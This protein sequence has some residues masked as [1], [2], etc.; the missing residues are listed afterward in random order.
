MNFSFVYFLV[1]PLAM[2]QY[3]GK[4]SHKSPPQEQFRRFNIFDKVN[5]LMLQKMSNS[6]ILE[7]F[8]NSIKT[9]EQAKKDREEQEKRNKIFRDYLA[10]RDPSS[11]SKDFHTLRY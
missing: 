6:K 2:A 9:Q 11:F 7:Q 8:R 3:P 4:N 5:I 1:L 10:S